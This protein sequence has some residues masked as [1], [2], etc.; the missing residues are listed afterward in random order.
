MHVFVETNWVF[1]CFAPKHRRKLAAKRLLESASRGTFRL[2]VPS[3]ALAEGAKT[4]RARC[5]PRG[6]DVV[7][8]FF[9]ARDNQLL[10]PETLATVRAF[11]DEHRKSVRD[12]LERLELELEALRE[13]PGIE[14]FP[15]SQAIFERMDDLQ[16]EL[17]P[18]DKLILAAVLTRASEIRQQ[19]PGAQLTFCTLDSDLSPKEGSVIAQ[20]YVDAGISFRRDFDV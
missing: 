17:K 9:F 4:I 20:L 12:D 14:V 13:R 8:W 18:Y 7:E 15:L 5:Q 11:L 16:A 1:D 3:A 2:H 6:G 19:E 10:P